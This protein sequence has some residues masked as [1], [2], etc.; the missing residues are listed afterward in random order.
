MTASRQYCAAVAGV[1]FGVGCVT[2]VITDLLLSEV[3]A[4]LRY[5]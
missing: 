5:F 1:P 3:P 4:L 2:I